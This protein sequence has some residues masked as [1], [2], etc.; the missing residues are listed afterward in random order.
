MLKNGVYFL[1][2]F[3]CAALPVTANAT[4]YV[5]ASKSGGDATCRVVP[6]GSTTIPGSS[7]F[8]NIS[9][10]AGSG[11]QVSRVTLDGASLC[12]TPPSGNI[13]Q[14]ANSTFYAVPY[15]AGKTYRTLVG[16]F[17][18]ATTLS[19]TVNPDVHTSYRVISPVNG[20]LTG[21]SRGESRTIAIIPYAG[22]AVGAVSAPGCSQA[23]STQF[24]GG[25]DVT[26]ANIQNSITINVGPS[27]I[28]QVVTAS[29]GPDRTTTGTGPVNTIT[30]S[31]TATYTIGPVTYA[32]SAV[33]A[34]AASV[35]LGTP[36]AA[37]TTFYA[38]F[39]GTYNVQLIA[40]AAGP[41]VSAPDLAVITVPNT[42]AT[43]ETFCTSC[44][45]SRNAAV[46]NDYDSS[47]HKT[48]TSPI[49]VCQTCHDPTGTGHYTDAAPVGVCAGC[50]TD[51]SG[52]VPG[53]PFA[54]GTSPCSAC[55]N[56]HSTAGTMAEAQGAPHYNNITGAGYPASFVTSRATC[57]DCHYDSQ[58]NF[59][60]RQ[61][62][63]T[64][65]HARTT[66]T[67]W[68]ANDFKTMTGCVQCH[69]TTGFIAYSSGKVTAA[70]G[71]ASDK[72]KELLTC[73]GCHKDVG[74]GIV[75]E[76]APVR[77]YADDSYVNRNVGESN[78]C[79]G[80]HS[81]ARNGQSV[82]KL[83][84]QANITSQ[85]IDPHS[86][87][88]G[89][90]LHG[91]A[92][93]QFS[94]QSYAFY[95]TNTHRTIGIGNKRGTGTAGPCVA[96]H[97]NSAN[98]HLFRAGV[99][100][101]CGNCHGTSLTADLL[102]AD[103]TAYAN[104]LDI[105]NAQLAASGFV[106]RAS[107][108]PR[109]NNRNWGTGQA[110]A[111]SMGAAFNY[112]L[113]H[114]EPGAYAH[115]PAYAKQLIFDSID[116][117]HNG[118]ITG[119]IDSAL[120]SLVASGAITQ[121]AANSITAYR[122]N[123]S[124]TTCH[125]NGSASHPAHL[126]DAIGCTN[127]HNATAATNTTI[128]P[129]TGTHFNGVTDV[130]IA[131]ANSKSGGASYNA[132]AC[133]G[134]TC[135][136]NGAV[137]WGSGP[138][139][140][141]SCHSGTLAVIN[142][143]TAPGKFLAMSS[144]HGKAG[145]GQP[146]LN[147]HDRSQRHI[148]GAGRLQ[149][150][151]TGTLNQECN[152]C[153]NDAA[154]VPDASFRNMST[155]FAKSGGQGA[156]ADCHEL[157]GTTN[158]SMIRTSISGQTITYN[159]RATGWV[160]TTTNLGLCQVCHTATGH[161]RAGVAETLHPA[162]GCF[163]CHTHNTPG[164]AFQPIGGSCDGCHGY[165]PPGPAPGYTGA[166]ETTS[167]HLKHA[168]GGANYGFA[169]D[170]CHKGNRHATYTY[171]DVFIDKNGIIAGPTAAYNPTARTCSSLY[172]HS[173]GA[174]SDPA[175]EYRT[176]A[177]S[178]TMPA[179][180]SGCHGGNRSS[181]APMNAGAHQAHINNDGVLGVSFG[182]V[183]C[184][185]A[186]VSNDR[187]ISDKRRHVNRLKDYSGA[188]AG[189]SASYNAATKLCT[190]IYCHSNGKQGTVAVAYVNPP[191]W[192]S[193]ASLG[194]NGCHGTANAKGAPDYPSGGAGSAT[195]NSHERHALTSTLSV[196][197]NCNNC[198]FLTTVSDTAIRSDQQPSRHINGNT[199][200]VS[201]STEMAG[202]LYAQAAK[203]CSVVYC[204]SNAA[205]FDKPNVYKS[206]TW[207]GGAQ[208]CTSCHDTGGNATGL[209]GRHA[210]HT[211]GSYGFTCGRCHANT[212]GFANNTTI[213]TP[214][215]HLNKVKDVAFKDGGSYNGTTMG[216]STYCHSDALGGP[217]TIAV[218]WSD[219][220]WGGST[221]E[222]SNCFYCHKGQ[223][224]DNT[225]DNCTTVGGSWD[226]DKGLCTPYVNMTSNGHAK[227]VGPQWIRKYPCT[228][229]H[230]AT[231][232]AATGEGG[233]II[234]G[235]VNPANHVNGVKDVVMA[236][237]WAI[238][239]RPAPSYDAN[240]KV[241]DN[242][243]CHSDG[244]TDPDTVKLFPWTQHGTEC[245]SC[246]GHPKGS[247]S[248]AGCHD[249]RTDSIG[250]VW[251]LPPV[252]LNGTSSGWPLGQEWKA[253]IPMFPNQG[254]GTARA[255]SHMRH[256][257]TNFTCDICHAAT[258]RASNGTTSC[259]GPSCHVAGQPL[260]AGSMKET[261][262]LVGDFHV[263]KTKDVTFKRNAD[264]TQGSYDPTNKTCSN[265][266]CH[267]SGVDPQWGGS[268]N[269]QVVC[270]SCHGTAAGD[271]DTFGTFDATG[272]KA[273]INLTQWVKSGHGRP[274]S[275]GPYPVS[276]NPAANFPGN[277]CWYCHDNNI[278]HGDTTN[279]FRLRQH[280]QFANR[281]QKECVYCHMIGQDGE[282]LSCHSNSESL[283][284]QMNG[285]AAVAK[286]GGLT[287]SSGCRAT[288]CHDTDAR[289][290][291]TGAGFWEQ[292]QK[293]DVRNQYLMMG[294]CLK[295]HDDD[296][297]GQCT[298]CHTAPA[299]N[300]FKYSL[301]F[302]PGTGFIKPQKAKA[303]S[304]H[305]GYK[306]NREYLE[307]GVWKGGKFCWDCHDPHG[308]NN[309]NG[310]PNIYMIQGQV[311]TSTDGKFGIPYTR[312]AVVFTRKQSGLDYART[313][314]PYN[315]ICNVCHSTG[316][317]HYRADGGDG[318]NSSR[319][320]TSCHEHRFT[321]SHADNQPCSTCHQN[322]PVPRHSAFGQPRECTKCH[323]GTIGNRID[324]MGQFG[325]TSHH[326]Q[327]TVVTSKQCYTCHWEATPE[328]LIDVRYHQGYNN[329]DN[330]SVKDAP[331]DLVVWGPGTRPAAYK[332]Y[333]TAVQ[334][335]AKNLSFGII[336]TERKEVAKLTPHCL[337]C[338]SDQNNNI[339]PFGDC[340]TPRQ[341]A[342][343]KQS[344]AARYS[345]T[346]TTQWGKYATNGKSGVTKA[347]SAHG[348]AVGNQGGYDPI[349]GVDGSI[350]NSR[351]G[352]YNVTCY[353]CHNSHGSRVVGTTSSYV[354]F[355]GTRNGANLKETQ[356]GKG[357]YT[358]SYKA[359]AN[360]DS[361]AVNPYSAG[362]GQC[363]DCHVTATPGTT[364]WGY[365][366]TFGASAA[367]KGYMDSPR[368]GQAP[369][370]MMV[371]YPYK[372]MPIAGGHLK[373][374]QVAGK[375][376]NHTTSAQNRIN[377]LC[378]PCH[379]PHGVTPTLGTRQA[380]GVPLLKGTWLTTPYKEDAADTNLN[381]DSGHT[382]RPFV[383]TDDRTFAAGKVSED[384]TT[385]AG[386]CLR[387]HQKKN[388][389]NGTDHTWKDQNRVHEAVKGWKTANGNQQHNYTCSKCHAP[390]DTGLK[391]LMV[392]NCLN[393]QH[394]GQVTSGGQAGWGWG[395]GDYGG[396]SGSFPLGAGN[397]GVNCHPGGAWPD[398]TWNNVTP[399]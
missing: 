177:W 56:A 323:A 116:Y 5:T 350:P 85:F 273:Q 349:N 31:G 276:G 334:Y 261:A 92:G 179:D 242:V 372:A 393:Y 311:A 218:K 193:G 296:S 258:I 88:A 28:S 327:G 148:G 279:P 364:P 287:Y 207:G 147:C 377:G 185:A 307:N 378:T 145:I 159:D 61:Q 30:L 188:R 328:G 142:G 176:P 249:G 7:G 22:Y 221:A 10:I 318:H 70:W 308:D 289:L 356:A 163:T 388:L 115:N 37:S 89:G 90:T 275:A 285:S 43:L 71:A 265:T 171:Q 303:S 42:T 65:G 18:A 332:L 34:N 80:C 319:V 248:S 385:F 102:T 250:N 164:G 29:A 222:K 374:S 225:Q 396:G 373:A 228:Y 315:G 165:P 398:N 122:T 11:F 270:L 46:V 78:I 44:H 300:P 189:G 245:N 219:P 340:K 370:A 255:N 366:T 306:H 59:T 333:S 336:T 229:C 15:V 58:A 291:N 278:V 251:V 312:A 233:K 3:C 1:L 200:D 359:T 241:C 139:T 380:Y 35:H 246:H 383:Y 41:T 77:P 137:S 180:C 247:C 254:P 109:F 236:S 153:H 26:C 54:I 182:C 325:G 203:S 82:A 244:T 324:V 119:S 124:C 280:Q 269:S 128:M 282:C 108:T 170:E 181:G 212:A 186:T 99:V 345:Q 216:C 205:P 184:H 316:S 160:N 392:T 215:L 72:S 45:S 239:G 158:R 83:A 130:V 172:C 357:G 197:L 183:E 353:D 74:A 94:G 104:A 8:K 365:Q 76:V 57:S 257:Q 304:V 329:L 394:R 14:C 286:H 192:N 157:H 96:C 322:K 391:R 272:T 51:Q 125:A 156:C 227:L 101:L 38:D 358:M 36:T 154:Q 389:T 135:H 168:G 21:I 220:K 343:D 395:S 390:H 175:M 155:H 138:V 6:A 169:C 351:S 382:P 161:Y 152:H 381:D 375:F 371:R 231:V 274:T 123:S 162:T 134:T 268:V 348:N 55:H 252:Y 211:G 68:A 317:Q 23:P 267:T 100:P 354:T 237:Q 93:Y 302:D 232:A 50:H 352:A 301:G 132:P 202:A 217:P 256:I 118:A 120:G 196:S 52:K 146:C 277:P 105:L 299:N 208:S 20:L 167:P 305:F 136:G 320:C 263:N 75:R 48:A 209:S 294:V 206:V 13:P 295:C 141:E 210:G 62:W 19:I 238:P 67:P 338:H 326:I 103:K 397:A 69:T 260:P 347:L 91:K 140:C 112:A 190:N 281:F 17:G 243:Y 73:K 195:A 214:A 16:Y 106:Y 240:T 2:F 198:H 81:G 283:A 149:S 234:D 341:Y 49:V 224:G 314:A 66:D 191:A 173:N 355:N 4:W 368:F 127:C 24:P 310:T 174:L 32:W 84:V 335:V 262:H 253:A 144:G 313:T 298:T 384:E 367:I 107:A 213:S 344:I 129:G 97:K 117:L 64:S 27:V 363:F 331:V 399:W 133:T 264:G 292:G 342:W 223:A 187:T 63:Y 288:A 259:T 126:N 369:S 360:P 87:A 361:A 271:T 40:T 337:G 290:H 201:F 362:A 114:S 230:N 226:P 113:L 166:D 321:D 79:M 143:N 60:I 309:S 95:S 110:G 293:D 284:P 387:C 178:G 379:D 39:P 330:T 204:H 25:K 194:C 86:L 199:G 12:I 33:G 151:F 339:Q 111:N 53:H 376:L 346:G 47:K 297:G 235:D 98:G 386:L 150:A 266:H 131:P 121:A 9:T